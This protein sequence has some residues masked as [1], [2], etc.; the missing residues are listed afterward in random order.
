M[1]TMGIDPVFSLKLLGRK[2]GELTL[3]RIAGYLPPSGAQANLPL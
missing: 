3:D 1:H 2:P